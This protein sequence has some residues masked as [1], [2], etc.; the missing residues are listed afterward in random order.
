MRWQLAAVLGVILLDL[1]VVWRWYT[2]PAMVVSRAALATARSGSCREELLVR[3]GGVDRFYLVDVAS[4]KL[5]PQVT[6][7]TAAFVSGQMTSSSAAAVAAGQDLDT[8]GSNPATPQP[9]LAKGYAAAVDQRDSW[10]GGP[11][12]P[13]EDPLAARLQPDGSVALSEGTDRVYSGSIRYEKGTFELFSQARVRVGVT[14]QGHLAFEGLAGQ[15]AAGVGSA[16][17]QV[18][19]RFLPPAPRL[20]TLSAP[21][22]LRV[23]KQAYGQVVRDLPLLMPV[24]TGASG[25]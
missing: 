13:L 4:G 10:I 8:S 19:I 15:A 21:V 7:G 20:S 2:A 17:T 16:A 22:R 24:A 25:I 1:A 5:G 18:L 11:C 14:P 9:T 6:I 23:Y 3:G 12:M